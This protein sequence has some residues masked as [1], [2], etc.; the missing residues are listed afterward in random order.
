MYSLSFSRLPITRMIITQVN[1]WHLNGPSECNPK[2]VTKFFL[3]RIE[4][5][6]SPSK[7]H[8][9][10]NKKWNES[11]NFQLE[12]LRWYTARSFHSMFKKVGRYSKVE[13]T[14]RNTRL[15]YCPQIICHPLFYWSAYY[16]TLLNFKTRELCLFVKIDRHVLA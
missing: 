7:T 6:L 8:L 12:S 15:L 16:L 5:K 4:A 3:A 13:F 1:F 9:K 14:Q 10:V 2:K 11:K